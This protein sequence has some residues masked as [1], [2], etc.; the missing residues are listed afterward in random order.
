MQDINHLSMLFA[1]HPR[2]HLEKASLHSTS[3][4]TSNA[5]YHN[6]MVV[7]LCGGSTNSA[8]TEANSVVCVTMSGK[9]EPSQRYHM[10]AIEQVSKQPEE[11][12]HTC[13]LK[14][15]LHM[16]SSLRLNWTMHNG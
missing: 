14:S 5:V 6:V 13:T 11:Y 8:V 7:P 3:T 12:K 2:T 1:H 9:V 15:W 10:V 16:Q 4:Q